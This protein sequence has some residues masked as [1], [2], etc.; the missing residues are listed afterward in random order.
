MSVGRFLAGFI[1]GGTLGAI[2]G[3]LLAPQSGEETREFLCDTS[4][5]IAEKTDKTVQEI[6]KKADTVA[7]DLQQKG[8]EI[9]EKLQILLNKQKKESAGEN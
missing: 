5:D 2:A 4:K 3:V 9:M 1:V 6:Q 7:S 8:D